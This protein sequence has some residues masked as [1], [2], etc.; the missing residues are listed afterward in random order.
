M[1]NEDLC[2]CLCE[3]F[4]LTIDCNGTFT[5]HG[6]KKGA[7]GVSVA[8][9]AWVVL[10][11]YCSSIVLELCMCDVTEAISNTFI[12]F[13]LYS[14]CMQCSTVPDKESAAI[15]NTLFIKCIAESCM[16]PK[17]I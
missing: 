15:A 17:T 1:V 14:S 11:L 5:V 10:Y 7:C 6:R 3:S 16:W 13:Y 4:F 9:N 8:P 2:F 12:K